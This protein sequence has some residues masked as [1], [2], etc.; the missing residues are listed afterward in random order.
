[1][2]VCMCVVHMCVNE[3]SEEFLCVKMNFS[4]KT[5]TH[6]KT[7]TKKKY[8][9]DDIIN[10]YKRLINHKLQTKDIYHWMYI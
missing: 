10:K 4:C 6:L 2:C 1:M 5:N 7:K 9:Y 3:D 8:K